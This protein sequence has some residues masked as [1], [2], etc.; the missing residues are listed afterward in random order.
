M[1]ALNQYLGILRERIAWFPTIDTDACS[2]CGECSEMCA[3]DVFAIDDET[4]VMAV[5]HPYNCV[6]LCDKCGPSCPTDALRF[7]DKQEAK[8]EISRLLAE[9]RTAA[10]R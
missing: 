9:R 3:N 6:V 8:A 4:G 5:V 7:P 1:P 10:V 2:A